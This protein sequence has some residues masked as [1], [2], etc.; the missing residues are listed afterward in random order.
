MESK[1]TKKPII[2]VERGSFTI[3]FNELKVIKNEGNNDLKGRGCNVNN[4]KTCLQPKTK[5]RKPA[6]IVR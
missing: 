4:T 1:Q 2:K 3:K 6:V 5:A